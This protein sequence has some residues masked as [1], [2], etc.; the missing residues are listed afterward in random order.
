[1]DDASRFPRNHDP[2]PSALPL[3][4]PPHRHLIGTS[5][6]SGCTSRCSVVET[7]DVRIAAV[8]D[9]DRPQRRGAPAGHAHGRRRP[10]SSL[11]KTPLRAI[12]VPDT[13]SHPSVWVTIDWIWFSDIP[14]PAPL[15][16]QC[17]DTS[18]VLAHGGSACPYVMEKVPQPHPAGASIYFTPCPKCPTVYDRCWSR[19]PPLYALASYEPT[20]TTRRWPLLGAVGC[21]VCVST[22]SRGTY[23]ALDGHGQLA[24]R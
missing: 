17:T 18:V 15:P 13:C 10:P 20:R 2:I 8:R 3:S 1:M 14:L 12:P 11:P 24:L 5:L 9:A 22:I 21:H 4:P 19:A 7:G 6:D 23:R 16:P